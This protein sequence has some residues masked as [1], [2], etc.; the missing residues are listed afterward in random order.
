MSK[1]QIELDEEEE[2]IV[3]HYKVEKSLGSVEKTL[4]LIIR[5]FGKLKGR[6][7]L[8]G[9]LRFCLLISLL[10][11]SFLLSSNAVF[12]INTT[13]P[14]TVAFNMIFRLNNSNT[15][16]VVR[17]PTPTP[18]FYTV[19]DVNVNNTQYSS[20]LTH[21][22]VCS[23]DNV[24]YA[25]GTTLA[26]IHSGKMEDLTYVNFYKATG[27]LYYT[28]KLKQKIEGNQLIM[29]FTKNTCDL[30]E[31]KMTVIEQQTIP[32]KAFSAFTQIVPSSLT[33]AIRSVY[34]KLQLNGT[35]RFSSG[36]QKICFSNEGVNN[37]NKPI[38]WGRLC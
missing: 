15:D 23:Y 8:I 2:K 18:I 30:V 37:A 25:N 33:I 3:G 16:D 32:N 1:H 29:P 35:D 7:G 27:S 21:A 12:A 14:Q 31:S 13:R 19:D 36:E 10:V 38:I 26:M 9:K 24:S 34:D 28:L 17:I 22:Y 5:E 4:K 6:K 20:N 11:F